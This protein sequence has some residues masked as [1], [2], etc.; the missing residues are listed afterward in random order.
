M[1]TDNELNFVYGNYQ[2]VVDAFLPGKSLN[3]LS[4]AEKRN[5]VSKE[6]ITQ[7]LDEINGRTFFLVPWAIFYKVV[8]ERHKL[9]I[10]LGYF[11]NAYKK[12]M[13]T[14]TMAVRIRNG[15][16]LV[17]QSKNQS[18]IPSLALGP[19]YPNRHGNYNDVP[20][21]MFAEVEPSESW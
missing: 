10:N 8:D 19:I 7:L 20:D 4:V 6:K 21:E 11:H 3:P 1:L 9:F 2:R 16:I 15:K 17:N 12:P 14:A 18:Y 13:G 5:N